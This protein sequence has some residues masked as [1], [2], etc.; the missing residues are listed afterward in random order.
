VFAVNPRTCQISAEYAR[1]SYIAKASPHP[2]R[3]TCISR[4]HQG[5]LPPSRYPSPSGLWLRLPVPSTATTHRMVHPQVKAPPAPTRHGLPAS[6]S[7]TEAPQARS[8]ATRTSSVT[9]ATTSC[10]PP[11]SRKHQHHLDSLQ[12][13]RPSLSCHHSTLRSPRSNSAGAVAAVSN[14]GPLSQ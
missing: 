7:S 14:G 5:L 6:L 2:T 11:F 9:T 1:K 8:S 10:R 13:P 12:W 3:A 4:H